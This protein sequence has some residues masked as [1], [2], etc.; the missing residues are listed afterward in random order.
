MFIFEKFGILFVF[1]FVHHRI[2]IAQHEDRYI[3]MLLAK[4]IGY[5]LSNDTAPKSYSL[6]IEPHFDSEEFTFDGTS[7]IV[8]EVYNP[9]QD[10]TFHT[11][12]SLKINTTYTKLIFP[13]GTIWEPV[14]QRWSEVLEFFNIKFDNE[15]PIG[16]YVLK[17]QWSGFGAKDAKGFYQASDRYS[18]GESAYVFCQ[19]TK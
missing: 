4:V 6:Q 2:S 7:K 13:N 18:N 15:L 3:A 12:S 1:I 16:L 10:V 14:T 8:F 11:A 17:L 9:T 5:R 19:S